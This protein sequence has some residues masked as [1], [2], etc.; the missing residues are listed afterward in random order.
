MRLTWAL[1]LTLLLSSCGYHLVGQGEST[2]IPHGVETAW[3]EA[4]ASSQGQALQLE[5]AALWQENS[6][7][8]ALHDVKPNKAHVTVRIEQVHETFSPIGFDAAG[9]AVQ[10][11]LSISA[12]LRM[13]Q[14]GSLIWQASGVLVSAD[15]FAGNDPSV[16]ESERARL[17]KQL[18]IS[19]AKSALA[20][21]QSGF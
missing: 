17:T 4:D 2:V 6:R 21:L 18:Q 7:L 19:W 5:L 15:V 12:T 1:L 14:A 8:P 10:Y 16:I 3:L 20:R 11:R 9:L 13:Y